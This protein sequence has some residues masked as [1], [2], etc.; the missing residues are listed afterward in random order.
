MNT[1][2]E[3]ELKQ[4]MTRREPPSDFAA[5]VLARAACEPKRSRTA[6]LRLW[7]VRMHVWRLVPVMAALLVMSGGVVYE[8]HQHA[9]RGELAKQKLLVAMQIAGSKLHQAQRR[10][11]DI[12]PAEVA[13]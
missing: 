12:Q 9:V 2:F 7:F 4:A 1:P 6:Q 5:R 10:V 13:Q 8:Q 3:E 11:F